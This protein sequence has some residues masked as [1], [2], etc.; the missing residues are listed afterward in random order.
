[1]EAIDCF[2][3]VY[4]LQPDPLII[5][6]IRSV[7]NVLWLS[8]QWFFLCFLALLLRTLVGPPVVWM[9]VWMPSTGAV[10][11]KPFR[12]LKGGLPVVPA[13]K[14]SLNN[15]NHHQTFGNSNMTPRKSNRRLFYIDLPSTV[16]DTMIYQ[17]LSGSLVEE[18]F[19][20][21]HVKDKHQRHRLPYNINIQINTRVYHGC[22]W[23]RVGHDN[24]IY[25]DTPSDF[26]IYHVKIQFDAVVNW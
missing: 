26:G 15:H 10:L 3:L 25:R 16:S 22:I 9:D 20:T 12:N 19:S 4:T 14:T 13:S 21:P 6:L 7:V 8:A 11:E 23:H 5:L 17:I 24:A 2:S 18:I 1:M